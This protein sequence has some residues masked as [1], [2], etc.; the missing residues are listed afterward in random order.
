MGITRPNFN[1]LN[2]YKY[3]TTTS[4]YVSGNPDLQPSVAHNAEI[5]YSFKGIYAVLYNS[6]NNDAI[7]YITRFNTDG[8]QFTIPENHINSNKTGLY[9]SYYRSLFGWWN[10]NLGGEVFH[11]YAKSK[12]A[13]YRDDDDSGWSGKVELSTSF[14]LNRQ[15]SL[16]LDVR[17]NHYFPYHERMI[18]YEAMSLFG[19]SLRYSLLNDRLTLTA[20]VSDPFGWNVTKSTAIYHDYS[21]YTRNDIHAHSVSFRISYSFG[22]SK[23][24]NVYRDTKE[25]E[26]NRAN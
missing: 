1:D 18:R 10:L 4:D 13:D 25:R 22:R 16:V 23:V 11:T 17:F 19:C 3:Y 20:S 21:V 9:A 24:N 5:S 6:Y 14:M 26:S 12:L 8:S 2:P 15:K 7:G